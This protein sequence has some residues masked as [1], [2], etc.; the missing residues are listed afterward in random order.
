MELS[1][2]YIIDEKGKPNAVVMDYAMF[3]KIED[4]LLDLGLAKAMTEVEDD[5]EYNL[6]TAKKLSS[7][8]ADKSLS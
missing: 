7:F 2:K 1:V 8:S 5:E 4:L 3:K 6:E